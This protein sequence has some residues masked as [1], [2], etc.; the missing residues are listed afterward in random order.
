MRT[1]LHVDD[2]AYRLAVRHAKMRGIRL[3]RAISDLIVRGARA[4]IPL[5]EQDGLL[6]FDPPQHLPETTT[7]QVKRLA[8][9]W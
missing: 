8:E 9:E 1:T 2:E 5:K 4:E 7:E 6:I 3:G